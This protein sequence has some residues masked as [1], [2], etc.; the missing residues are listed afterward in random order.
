[1]LVIFVTLVPLSLWQKQQEV[2]PYDDY[3]V[4]EENGCRDPAG[5]YDG[6]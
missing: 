5:E 6:K 2:V 3:D 1:M 4:E